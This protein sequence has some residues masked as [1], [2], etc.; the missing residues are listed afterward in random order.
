VSHGSEANVSAAK[1]NGGFLRRFFA[2]NHASEHTAATL[3]L[4]D[5]Q[6]FILRGVPH[7]DCAAFPAEGE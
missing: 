5:I 1:S 4:K 6:G 7:A 3:D 2:G